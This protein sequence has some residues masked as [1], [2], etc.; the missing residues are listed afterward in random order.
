MCIEEISNDF[1]TLFVPFFNKNKDVFLSWQFVCQQQYKMENADTELFKMP[2]WFNSFIK[3]NKN[4]GFLEKE[5]KGQQN[6]V[7]IWTCF[8]VIRRV[9]R[10]TH[11]STCFH[12]ISTEKYFFVV[13]CTAVEKKV[14]HLNSLHIFHSVLSLLSFF[15]IKIFRNS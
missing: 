3:V 15:N 11:G 13:F 2:I 5:G 10:N 12:I 1:N 14:S 6:G 4:A 8:G 9:A 7:E